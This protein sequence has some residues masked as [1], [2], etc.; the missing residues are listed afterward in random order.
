MILL[1][2]TSITD[3]QDLS[4]LDDLDRPNEHLSA[5]W[6]LMPPL[7]PKPDPSLPGLPKL[8]IGDNEKDVKGSR[9]AKFIADRHNLLKDQSGKVEH[10]SNKFIPS[11]L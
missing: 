11:K 6:A 2:C 8:Q 9:F 7:S 5:I 10:L 3:M 4:L 1:V